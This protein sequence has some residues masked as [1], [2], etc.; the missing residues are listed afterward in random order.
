MLLLQH[1]CE[2]QS[3]EML[4]LT[5][6]I[7]FLYSPGYITVNRAF[8]VNSVP[9]FDR[10]A[11]LLLSILHFYEKKI[12]ECPTALFNN[13]FESSAIQSIYLL[14]HTTDKLYINI[15]HT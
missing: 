6:I 13:Q 3:S 12:Q 14:H 4:F 10:C 2:I 8:T 15:E 9:C 1:A 11:A 5:C 7:V